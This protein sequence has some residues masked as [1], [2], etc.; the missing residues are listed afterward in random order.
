M[1]AQ[2]N[3]YTLKESAT[4]PFAQPILPALIEQTARQVFETFSEKMKIALSPLHPALSRRSALPC[5]LHPHILPIRAQL[6][7]AILVGA[8]QGIAFRSL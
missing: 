1:N 6:D 2:L 4:A 3:T 8:Q 7:P 5:R